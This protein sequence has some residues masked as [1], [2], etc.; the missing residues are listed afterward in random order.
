VNFDGSSA[1]TSEADRLRLAAA[2]ASAASHLSGRLR[3]H[4]ES[5]TVETRF[6][7]KN[8]QNIGKYARLVGKY[9]RLLGTYARLV[10]KHTRLVGKYARNPRFFC[11]KD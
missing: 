11:P 5:W 9:A 1:A 7:G 6:G 10:G 2:V 4:W 8:Q 3:E